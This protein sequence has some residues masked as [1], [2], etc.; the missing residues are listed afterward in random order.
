MGLIDVVIE[1]S[2]EAY[3]VQALIPIVEAAGGAMT[4]WTGAPCHEGGK[5][6]ACGDRSLHPQVVAL[7]SGGTG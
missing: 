5:V 6:L 1:A 2:L 7:L 3:D 4:D